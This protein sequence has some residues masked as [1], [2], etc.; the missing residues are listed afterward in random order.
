MSRYERLVATLIVLALLTPAT[1]L[2]AVC[3]AGPVVERIARAV[4][5]AAVVFVSVRLFLLT[6]RSR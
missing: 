2:L 5:I 4:V 6:R 1:A 3:G